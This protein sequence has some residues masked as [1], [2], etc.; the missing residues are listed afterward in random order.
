M[1]LIIIPENITYPITSNDISLYEELNNIQINTF[2]LDGYTDDTLDVRSC[3][4]QEYKSN[5]Y[6]KEVVNLLITRDGDK[7][8]YNLITNLSALFFSK[9]LKVARFHCPHCIV[10]C[11]SNIELLNNY[12]EKCLNTDEI[13]RVKIGVVCECPAEGENILQFKNH[14]NKFKH[15]FHIIAD[16][17]STLEKCD[18]EYNKLSDNDK[19]EI[20]NI[21]C[22]NIFKIHLVLN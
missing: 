9:T 19:E 1:N 17:E 15:P 22:R 13:D 4:N 11:Y 2:L 14:G 8:H 18:D 12:I 10:K 20:K 6:R 21:R 16:F 7:S 5:K 3:I